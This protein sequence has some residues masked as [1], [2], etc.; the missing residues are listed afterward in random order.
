[1]AQPHDKVAP[2]PSVPLVQLVKVT[3]LV[4]I[5]S[6]LQKFV[7]ISQW[8]NWLGAV[9]SVPSGLSDIDYSQRISGKAGE[10]SSAISKASELLPWTPSCLAQAFAGQQVIRRSGE[11]GIVV[12]GLRPRKKKSTKTWPA[13]AWLIY[14]GQ[15]ITG[16][17]VSHRYFPAS[18]HVI[19]DR[20][21]ALGRPS[22][23]L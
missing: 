19:G 16:G 1:M 2:S 23:N 15:I 4:A 7:P 8:S 9:E 17:A 21:A 6:L 11:S 5:G 12:I 14:Q 22:G 18:A 3:L 20:D 10:L 13:H